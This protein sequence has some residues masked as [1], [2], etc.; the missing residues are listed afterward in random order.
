MLRVSVNERERQAIQYSHSVIVDMLRVSVNEREEKW[1]VDSDPLEVPGIP[2]LR[3]IA[4]E[5]LTFH[6]RMSQVWSLKSTR[7]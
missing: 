3:A 4:G 1:S 6:E 2:C 5:S 7:Y